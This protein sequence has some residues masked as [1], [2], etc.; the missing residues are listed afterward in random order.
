MNKLIRFFLL[1]LLLTIS[2]AAA[3][4]PS[5]TSIPQTGGQAYVPVAV[6]GLP[7]LETFIRQVKTGTVSQVTGL[8]VADVFAY[9]VVQQ[10]ADKP[11]YVS[12]EDGR[13]T[14]FG[15][16][17]SYGSLGFL[18]HNTLAGAKFSDIKRYQ[19]INVVYGDG[20]YVVFQVMEIHRF[21]ATRP[22]SPYSS[23]VDLE[24]NKS[25][26]ATDLFMQTYGV[27]NTL[28]LQ[29]CITSKG[30]DTWGRLFIIATPYYPEPAN[31]R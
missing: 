8:Y 30:V 31:N 12:L 13:I 6:A 1:A 25:L 3:P 2:L 23:F 5:L 4:F 11:A 24:T 21:Q 22:T 14:Q 17:S 10:P 7:S 19:L 20:H 15:M 27:K 9:P 16:A 18:A 28:V 29:T 26:T